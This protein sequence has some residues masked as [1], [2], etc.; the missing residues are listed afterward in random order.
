MKPFGLRTLCRKTSGNRMRKRTQGGNMRRATV[1][2]L[3]SLFPASSL[4]A[5]LPSP[6]AVLRKPVGQDRVLASYQE[7]VVYLQKLAELTPRVRVEELG[8]TVAGRPMVAAVVSSAAN[9]ARLEAIR[10][11]W[12]Q[13]ADPRQLTPAEREALLRD[14]PAGLLVTA[15][16]HATEVA[17]PQAVLLFAHEL[18]S[19]PEDTAIGRFLSRVVVLLVPSL[20]PDGQEAVVAW[21]EK[22]LG[23][24]FEG[25]PP[26]FLYHPYAGHDN[27][28]DFVF[29]TQ[30]ESRTLNRFVY[31]RWHPQLFVDLHQMGPVGPRQFVPPFADP[32]NTNLPPVIWRLTSH[33]GTLM[34]LRLEQAGKSGVVSGWT[35]DGHWIGGTRNT[36]WWKNIFGV[37]TETASA[38]LATPVFVDAADLR[39]GGKGLWEYQPQVHFP[40]PWRGG[41]WGL[42]EA[43][44]YQR[45]LLRAALEFAA[46][47]RRDLLAESSQM[48]AEA[49]FAK[50]AFWGWVVPPVGD[51][52]RRQ[53]LVTL[54]SEAGAETFVAEE[55]LRSGRVLVPKGSVLIPQAQPLAR[56]LREVLEPQEYPEVSP[57]PGADILVP[58]DITAWNLPLMLGVE[59][60]RVAETPAGHWRPLPADFGLFHGSPSSSV[61]AL[62][63]HHLWL[64]RVANEALRAGFAPCR[65]ERSAGDDL[66]PG[67]LVLAGAAAKLGALVAG[68]PVVPVKLSQIPPECS[69]LRAPRVGVLHPYTP[70][71]DAGWLRWVLEQGGFAVTVVEPP[72][73]SAG[74]LT[75]TLDVLVLPDVEASRLVD[76]PATGLVPL[77]PEYRVGIGKGGAQSLREFVEAGGTVLAFER[78]AEWLAEVFGLPLTNAL[79]GLPRSEFFAPGALV[80]MELQSE[81][82]YT[83]GLPAEAAAM[84]EGAVAFAP[85]P[86]PV[87]MREVVAR[88]PE[89]PRVLSGFLRGDEHLRRKA[90]MLAFTVGKGRV[91]LYS[92]AP[93]FRGQTANLFPLIYNAV[94]LSTASTPH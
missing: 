53:K 49:I 84:V 14:L 88:F 50:N 93:H 76:G 58:Y 35:F 3:V 94:W 81:S 85:R 71:E 56:F 80:T 55:E 9:M 1:L 77:P 74:K 29:L 43:V 24:A 79:K 22:Y 30:P 65:L 13:L 73:V 60:M 91:V 20:N 15:G 57:A 89:K 59:V 69:V 41:R 62:P 63:A 33:L 48:A 92:F 46:L 27:N 25:S 37:L 11:G 86:T 83:W 4:F 8:P 38:A 34:G 16:I 32:I 17:G 82:P 39:G 87:G 78:T 70:V 28:R 10:R 64:H 52:G 18:A 66:A 6:E 31:H 19:A 67:S 26:P 68:K 44:S 40:N 36:A 7:T 12:A 21:Y 47:Y 51:P 45:E 5:S 54:L 42:S 61:M 2:L 23:T 72:Q 90:A 75:E